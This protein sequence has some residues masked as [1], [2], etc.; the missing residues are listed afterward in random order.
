MKDRRAAANGCPAGGWPYGV[1]AA[2][3]DHVTSAS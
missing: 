3:T 1:Q 2:L